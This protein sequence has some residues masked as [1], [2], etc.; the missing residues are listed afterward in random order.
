MEFI[1]VIVVPH[2]SFSKYDVNILASWECG[3]Q[4]SNAIK[5]IVYDY[6]IIWLIASLNWVIFVI[7]K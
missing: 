2:I 5:I 6:R 1:L 3:M 7:G 4:Q